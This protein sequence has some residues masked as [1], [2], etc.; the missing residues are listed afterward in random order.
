MDAAALDVADAL[1]R[2]RSP[3]SPR[4][5]PRRARRVPRPGRAGGRA[6]R[7]VA[8]A[9]AAASSSRVAAA[10]LRRDR[11][12]ERVRSESGSGSAAKAFIFDANAAR[13]LLET[14]V[15]AL[16]G[17]KG[18]APGGGPF[19]AGKKRKGV[20]GA[21]GDASPDDDERESEDGTHDAAG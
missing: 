18:P 16:A 17:P 10:R 12:L 6:R 15:S 1:T 13:L 21:D 11:P 19:A 14:A 3:P 5:A 7:G 4:S 8:R 9:A 2:P 20:V